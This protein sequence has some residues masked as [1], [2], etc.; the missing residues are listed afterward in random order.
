MAKHSRRSFL[1]ALLAA[2]PAAL[3]AWLGGKKKARAKAPASTRR[4]VP[5]GESSTIVYS[6]D[7]KGRL[8]R[9]QEIDAVKDEPARVVFD[10]AQDSLWPNATQGRYGYTYDAMPDSFDLPPGPANG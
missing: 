7:A 4:H 6:Y 3:L 5:H 2:L 10:T 9:I 8:I 1:A